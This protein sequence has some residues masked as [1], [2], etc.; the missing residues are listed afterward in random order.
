MS[1]QL[2]LLSIFK[3]VSGTLSD[4]QSALNEADSYNGD[5]GDNM[6]NI[7]NLVTGAMSDKKDADTSEQLAYA[8]KLLSKEKSGSAQAYAKGLS[9]AAEQFQG[10]NITADGVMP[11]LQSLFSAGE[12]PSEPA[13]P[14]QGLLGGLLGGGDDDG[15]DAGDLLNAGMSFFSAKSSGK[16]SQEALIEAVISGSPM[17]KSPHRA[18]S[19]QMVASTVLEMLGQLGK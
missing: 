6:V 19:S 18:Q 2:D 14:L 7:F 16:S 12:T 9:S 1:N 15:L 3:A 10:Q 4:N 13:S 11:L 8:S 17:G 5:H